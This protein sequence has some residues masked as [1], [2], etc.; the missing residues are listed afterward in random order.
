MWFSWSAS[1]AQ[2]VKTARHFSPEHFRNR[3]Q[4]DW[5]WHC[6]PSIDDDGRDG[7]S[8]RVLSGFFFCGV[9]EWMTLAKERF[10]ID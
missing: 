5:N 2:L 4:P 6:N 1:A 8:A 3:K 7:Y 9:L 10:R